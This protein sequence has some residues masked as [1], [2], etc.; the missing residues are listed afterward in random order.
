VRIQQLLFLTAGMQK[1]RADSLFRRHGITGAQVGVLVSVREET[2]RPIGELGVEL[3]CDVSNVT[4]LVTRLERLGMVSREAPPE[5]RRVSLIR[6]TPKG[7]KALAGVL[8][9]HEEALI[10]DA[11]RLTA[12]EREMLIHCLEKLGGDKC[13]RQKGRT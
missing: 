5:D 2:G 13:D 7:T 10:G 4:G 9:A 8:P 12:S 1:R 3:W 11:N 6:R